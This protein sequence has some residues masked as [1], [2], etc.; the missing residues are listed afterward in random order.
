M[1]NMKKHIY[2]LA[3]AAVL[4][5]GCSS[6]EDILQKPSV[7]PASVSITASF[8]GVTRAYTEDGK[9]SLWSEDEKIYVGASD[10]MSEYAITLRTAD[11]TK[12]TFTGTKVI[13][14]NSYAVYGGTHTSLPSISSS[15]AVSNITIPSE[16]EYDAANNCANVLLMGKVDTTDPS[17]D[18]EFKHAGAVLYIQLGSEATSFNAIK[19]TSSGSSTNTTAVYIS[20]EATISWNST[21]NVPTYSCAES[22]N[23]KTIT[24]KASSDKFDTNTNIVVPVPAATYGSLKVEG[25][26]DGTDYNTTIINIEDFE[27]V[28]NKSYKVDYSGATVTG[29]KNAAE[30]YTALN[31]SAGCDVKLDNDI[32]LGSSEQS[33]SISGNKASVVDL[34]GKTLTA[35]KDN[36]GKVAL[37]LNVGGSDKATSPTPYS[38]SLT[39]KNGTIKIDTSATETELTITNACYIHLENINFVVPADAAASKDGSI[40]QTYTIYLNIE[41]ELAFDSNIPDSDDIIH[42]SYKDCTINAN[43]MNADFFI[44]KNFTELSA[45]KTYD[46]K[47]IVVKIKKAD[48]N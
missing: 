31:N 21:D 19:V 33:F 43:T 16:W 17:K 34:N 11:N 15:Q 14:E 26:A 13:A 36:N 4:A 29:I 24:I 47:T 39:I 23:G 27:I 5:A 48:S 9:K 10:A 12:A 45:T 44:R 18:V 30:L 46:N 42:F 32:T 28:R 2:L 7:D 20:G 38:Q 22:D 25:S 40:T 3:C 8:D 6:E 1:N 41:N 35:Q 37:T